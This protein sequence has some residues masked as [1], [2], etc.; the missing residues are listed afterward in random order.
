MSIFKKIQW[1]G[2]KFDGYVR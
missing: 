2:E 1:N